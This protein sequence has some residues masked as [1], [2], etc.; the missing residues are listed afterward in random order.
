M[1][2]AGKTKSLIFRA[3]GSGKPIASTS[4][5]GHNAHWTAEAASCCSACSMVSEVISRMLVQHARREYRTWIFDSRRWQHY[6]PRPADVREI[7]EAI[8]EFLGK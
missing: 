4:A 6:R 5:L 8:G 7:A 3:G 1:V 2:R